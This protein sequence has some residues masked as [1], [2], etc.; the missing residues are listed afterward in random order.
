MNSRSTAIATE[1]DHELT[2]VVRVNWLTYAHVHQAGRVGLGRYL[3]SKYGFDGE[4]ELDDCPNDTSFDVDLSKLS[5]WDLK[6]AEN[7]KEQ[8]T[9]K[10]R[11]G[12]IEYYNLRDALRQAVIDE[13][14]PP[15]RYIVRMSW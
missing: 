10:L 13:H 14:L 6:F 11:S 5:D 1:L 12:S 4:I 2:I 15:A 3:G 9:A 8:I 7:E